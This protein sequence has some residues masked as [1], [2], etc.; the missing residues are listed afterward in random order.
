MG[1][2]GPGRVLLL[3]MTKTYR[4][5]AFLEAAE[6]LRL[7]V[8]V[9]SE[10]TH[11]LAG[12][13]PDGHLTL[14]FS[15]LEGSVEAIV[16]YA[17]RVPIASVIAT[18]DDGITLAALASD[19]LKLRHNPPLA[20]ATCRDKY[21]TR[22]ALCAAG[23]RCPGFA[24][25]PV[26][27]DPVAI[28]R[29]VGY[30]CVLKPLALSASRGVIRANDPPELVRAWEWIVGIVAKADMPVM[31]DADR[32]VLVEEYLDG[33]E[34]AVEGLLD[35]GELTVLAIFDKPDPLAGP[36][37]EETIY[38]TPSRHPAGV[39][40]VIIE[41]TRRAVHV[42]G[43]RDGPV[44]VELRINAEGP[45]IL[46]VA[47][48]SIGGYCSRALRFEGGAALEDL[49]LRQAMGQGIGLTNPATPASGVMM[50]PIPARGVLCEVQGVEQARAVPLIEDIRLTIPIGMEVVPPPEGARYLGFIFARGETPEAVEA[51]LREAHGRLGFVIDENPTP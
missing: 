12:A 15:D 10:L 35:G 43:L 23:M 27:A 4:A 1:M 3:M 33:E 44:H 47:P 39:Q 19:A 21:L 36:Y 13:N 16:E 46:E 40:T 24:R 30:P 5:G 32:W 7:P 34:V 48:R 11:V 20:V 41:E 6:R 9:G 37:F 25:Y 18:D 26:D 31:G 51:A 14:D 50:I 8:A 45:W 17:K 42:L 22:R 49:I 2:S 38:V 28:S 29:E